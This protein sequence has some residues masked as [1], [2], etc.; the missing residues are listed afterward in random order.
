MTLKLL[1]KCS[2]RWL[3]RGQQY[4]SRV[5]FC[6]M[7]IKHGCSVFTFSINI[8]CFYVSWVGCFD[9]YSEIVSCFHSQH[10]FCTNLLNN[11]HISPFPSLPLLPSG[12]TACPC[13]HTPL[14][15]F[16]EGIPSTWSCLPWFLSM[17]TS[18][19]LYLS[20]QENLLKCRL[21]G[22]ESRI[23]YR[24]LYFSQALQRVLIWTS[25]LKDF[26]HI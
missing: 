10:L 23:G 6:Q 8:G 20:D 5:G 12:T 11:K 19:T 26:V 17:A 16:P 25:N 4:H 7:R 9:K 2:S 13:A 1:G 14:H 3:L 22:P 24:N 15:C 18:Y 21:S